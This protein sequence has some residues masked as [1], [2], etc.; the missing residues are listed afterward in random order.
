MTALPSS[1]WRGLVPFSAF[2]L[3]AGGLYLS[4]WR[5]YHVRAP[6]LGLADARFENL[7]PHLVEPNLV[8][9]PDV[10][11]ELARRQGRFVLLVFWDPKR[12]E[13]LC[14]LPGLNRLQRNY[15]PRGLDLIGIL[16]E[17]DREKAAEVCRQNGVG[18][19]QFADEQGNREWRARFKVGATNYVVLLNRK[20]NVVHQ[21]FIP[22][23]S[24]NR[25]IFYTGILGP[26]NVRTIVFPEVQGRLLY[27]GSP[28]T[29]FSSGHGYVELRDEWDVHASLS[30]VKVEY[31]HSSGFFRI[32]NLPEGTYSARVRV[33]S[34]DTA[35]CKFFTGSA[36][37][38]VPGV[39]QARPIEFEVRTHIHLRQPIDNRTTLGHGPLIHPSPVTFAWEPVPKAEGYQYSLLRRKALLEASKAAPWETVQSAATHGTQY[40]LPLA[41]GYEYSFS[42]RATRKDEPYFARLLVQTSAGPRDPYT[43]FV[44]KP[45]PAEKP[46]P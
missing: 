5:Y 37:F 6:Q 3:L 11:E 15:G 40:T 18:W 45:L 14:W 9:T 28:I 1:R 38:G 35:P 34:H 25:I 39:P 46:P 12:P 36:T 33:G 30:E 42:L 2:L 16:K 17:P 4:S 41:D 44:S 22:Q 7:K 43:F 13:T 21:D 26:P 24:E 20:G 23:T 19:R 32:K 8:P 10:D 29:D 27:L 31:A